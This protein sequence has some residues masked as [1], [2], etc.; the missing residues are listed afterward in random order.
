[1]MFQQSSLKTL[2]QLPWKIP[3]GMVFIIFYHSLLHSLPESPHD[4]SK[5][6]QEMDHTNDEL[7]T[8]LALCVLL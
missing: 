7:G 8:S 2:L 1:M 5:V 6:F 4:Y 3:F